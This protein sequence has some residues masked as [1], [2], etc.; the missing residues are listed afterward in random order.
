ME[1]LA[2]ILMF[3][4][5]ILI[6]YLIFVFFKIKTFEDEPKEWKDLP[7]S[8]RVYLWIGRNYKPLLISL[9]VLPIV[10]NALLFFLYSYKEK[11]KVLLTQSIRNMADKVLVLYPN[12]QIASLYLS[13]L[14]P[15]AVRYYL[16]DIVLAYF[17]W[18]K[19][20]LFRGENFARSYDE[21]PKYCDRVRNFLRL[22]LLSKKGLVYYAEALKGIYALAKADQLP[23]VIKPEDINSKIVVKKEDGKLFFDYTAKV[24]TYLEFTSL[25]EKGIQYGSGVYSVKLQGEINP[26]VGDLR[27]PFGVKITY[28]SLSPPIKPSY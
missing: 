12:G 23:E 20:C 5:L 14:K 10:A 17:I 9:F 1:I 24:K 22:G 25:G 2:Y 8:L 16:D 6:G 3:I 19:T 21:I 28:V 11:E 27:N 18:G 13:D 15:R 4:S 7:K 26:E